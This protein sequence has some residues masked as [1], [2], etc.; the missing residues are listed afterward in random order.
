[1]FVLTDKCP[2]EPTYPSELQLGSELRFRIGRNA[3]S[4]WHSLSG[5]TRRESTLLRHRLYFVKTICL[6]RIYAAT[7]PVVSKILQKNSDIMEADSFT[8]YFT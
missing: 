5:K 2:A 3:C 6:Y 4:R 7:E 8:G 1:L